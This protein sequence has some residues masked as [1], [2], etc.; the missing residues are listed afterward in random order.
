M[1][2]T[3]DFIKELRLQHSMTQL[4]IAKIACVSDRAVSAWERGLKEPRMGAIQRLAD[5]FG[6]KNSDFIDGHADTSKLYTNEEKQ[7]V[8]D[9]RGLSPEGQR[10]LLKYMRMLKA[11]ENDQA[12]KEERNLG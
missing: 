5:Y 6:L 10:D 9:F 3:G 2:I 11:D 1:T 8:D 4:E 12:K 7:L